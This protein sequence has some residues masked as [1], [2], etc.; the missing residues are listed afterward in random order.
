MRLVSRGLAKEEY[1]FAK[2]WINVAQ[3]IQKQSRVL[4]HGFVFSWVIL[5]HQAVDTFVDICGSEQIV[6]TQDSD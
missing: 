3:T 4:K 5:T 6:K 1:E 2:S